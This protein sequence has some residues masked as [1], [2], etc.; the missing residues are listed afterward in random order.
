MHNARRD[1][2]L[3]SFC[4]HGRRKSRCKDCGTGHIAKSDSMHGRQRSQCMDCGTGHCKHG[5]QRS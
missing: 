2:S 4:Q 1:C 3:K 5:R